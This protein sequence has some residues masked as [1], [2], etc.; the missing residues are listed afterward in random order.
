MKNDFVKCDSWMLSAKFSKDQANEE[1]FHAE[2]FR[3]LDEIDRLE[4]RPVR[5]RSTNKE[6]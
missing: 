5:D 3:V 6:S 1:D 2:T 4:G